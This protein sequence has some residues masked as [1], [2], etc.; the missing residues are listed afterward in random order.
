MSI[1]PFYLD[2]A[3]PGLR[4]RI[5]L[6]FAEK[7]QGFNPMPMVRS[8]LPSILRLDAMSDAELASLGLT[9]VL[10]HPRMFLKDQIVASA[11]CS[12]GF[13]FPQ[14]VGSVDCL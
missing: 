5:D 1:E 11:D 12:R 10:P 6:F 8:R 4:H 13:S 2:F 14:A 9:R 3:R 7:G